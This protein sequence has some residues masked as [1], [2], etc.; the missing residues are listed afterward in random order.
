[1]EKPT[2]RPGSSAGELIPLYRNNSFPPSSHTSSSPESI[3]FLAA[4]KAI[5]DNEVQESVFAEEK[6]K[7]TR[8]VAL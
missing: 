5:L 2:R 1:V 8:H 4:Q 6:A 7:R 3:S